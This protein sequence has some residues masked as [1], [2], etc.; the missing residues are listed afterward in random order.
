MNPVSIL[1]SL[2]KIPSFSREEKKVAD[3]FEE[4]MKEV[5]NL[6]IQRYKNNLWVMSPCFDAQKPT[7]LLAA[8]LDT[9]KPASNWTKDPFS[10][11]VED[12]KLF[13]L[14]SN[15]DGINV[16]V[17]LAVFEKLIKQLQPYNLIFAATAEEEVS[18]KNGIESLLNQLPKIDFAIIGEPTNLNLAIAEKGLLVLDVTAKGKSAHAAR[19][20]GE[21]AVYKALEA[22]DWF[23]NYCFEKKSELLGAVKMTVTQINAGTQHNV[24]PDVCS[25]VIDVRTNEL[26]TNQEVVDIIKQHIGN[27]EVTPRS[28]RLNSTSTP[29]NK[30]IEKAIQLGAKTFGSPT[31]SDQALL[32]FPS[33]KIGTGDSA[34]S[35]TADEYVFISEIEKGIDFFVA[36]LNGTEIK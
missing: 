3:F 18:G 20:E 23:R 14:G 8:H 22:I 4:K 25:F 12:G 32:P 6:D 24:I 33:V 15:D 19:N 7:I 21:N 1:Q 36:W 28:L 9:V 13:G 29:H 11:A 17:F 5:L 35:H 27:C 2:I 34:R 16:V 10:A 30:L 26:Y 31:L